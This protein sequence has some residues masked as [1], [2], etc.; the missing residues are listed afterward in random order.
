M[1]HVGFFLLFPFLAR[2]EL[3]KVFHLNS[4]I[5]EA[6]RNNNETKQQE[7]LPMAFATTALDA[8]ITGTNFLVA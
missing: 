7:Q 1:K 4:Y 3:Q 6:V 2:L 8:H 5:S